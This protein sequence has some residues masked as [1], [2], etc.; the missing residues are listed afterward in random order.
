M[1]KSFAESKF[2]GSDYTMVRNVSIKN[3]YIYLYIDE[4]MWIYIHIYI[5]I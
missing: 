2:R 1:K 4:I 3:I 5:Y